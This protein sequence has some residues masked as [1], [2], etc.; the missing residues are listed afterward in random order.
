VCL[1]VRPGSRRVPRETPHPHRGRIW[2]S[3]GSGTG[4]RVLPRA[5]SLRSRRSRDA[6][7]S[8]VEARRRTHLRA[9]DASRREGGVVVGAHAAAPHSVGRGDRRFVRRAV[10]LRPRARVRAHR[11][12]AAR[13]LVQ[14]RAVRALPLR[15]R[16]ASP[17][18]VPRRPGS[19][20]G[21]R[22]LRHGRGLGGG[23]SAW[24]AGRTRAR[25]TNAR[26]RDER[27][28]PRA[29]ARPSR[30][31]RAPRFSLAPPNPGST[32]PPLPPR[33][34]LAALCPNPW[35]KRPATAQ[36]CRAA[37]AERHPATAR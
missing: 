17:A 29:P 19:P 35:E 12:Q 21:R 3:L 33:R 4:A 9:H 24:G 1:C 2:R 13:R 14:K 8:R 20:G 6:R 11:A 36:L 7:D 28:C 26:E 31:R 37:D 32:R 15:G 22:R 23:V 16:R 25:E 10:L 27:A 5:T 34:A 18:V 30:V